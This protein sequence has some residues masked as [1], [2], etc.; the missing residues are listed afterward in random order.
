VRKRKRE[1]VRER[2]KG[3]TE[4]RQKGNE[5]QVNEMNEGASGGKV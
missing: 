1:R 3:E 4:G 5:H 2:V